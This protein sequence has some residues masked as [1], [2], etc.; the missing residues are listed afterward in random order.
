[1][2]EFELRVVTAHGSDGELTP[3]S[4]SDVLP[5]PSPA[6][7]DTAYDETRARVTELAAESLADPSNR[8]DR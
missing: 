4:G 2:F 5:A 1:M 7:S 8:W 3:L 6:A